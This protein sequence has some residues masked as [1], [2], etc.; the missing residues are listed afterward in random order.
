M[1]WLAYAFGG[2]NPGCRP[3]IRWL[4]WKERTFGAARLSRTTDA[5]AGSPELGSVAGRAHRLLL[6]DVVE[7][8]GTMLVLT[9]CNFEQ[10]GGR[11]GTVMKMQVRRWVELAGNGG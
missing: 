1:D 4:A 7:G 5:A 9:A 11:N 6:R 3:R 2:S 8:E 10:R